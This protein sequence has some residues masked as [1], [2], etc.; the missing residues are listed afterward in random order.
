MMRSAWITSIA[1]TLAG[2]LPVDSRRSPGELH[3]SVRGNQAMADGI[4]AT[5]D[6]W[7]I[8][9]D[10]FFATIGHAWPASDDCSP[11][12]DADYDR[13][14]DARRTEPQKLALLF[15]EGRCGLSFAVTAPSEDSLVTPGVSERDKAFLRKSGTPNG[16]IAVFVEGSATRGEQTKRFS[17]SY[18]RFTGYFCG[19]QGETDRRFVL[20]ENEDASAAV[21]LRGEALFELDA[22]LSPGVLRFDPFAEADDVWGDG[23]GA[24]ASSE[25]ERTPSMPIGAFTTLRAQLDGSL[26]PA[27]AVLEQGPCDAI[28]LNDAPLPAE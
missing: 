6:G 17:W 7:T 28:P 26:F 10:R 15:A 22:Q 11:Y 21:I 9:Y 8:R 1:V 3:V 27:L 20:R 24:I 25:L 13:I 16:G 19:L 4:A 12:S 18:G 23:N 2:C 5:A 14:V